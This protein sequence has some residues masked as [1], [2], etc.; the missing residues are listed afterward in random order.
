MSF[1]IQYADV[2]GLNLYAM[3]YGADH[4]GSALQYQI[5]QDMA[6]F[7]SADFTTG[8][9]IPLSED[10]V[11]KGLYF[12][13]ALDSLAPLPFSQYNDFNLVIYERIGAAPYVAS[14]V[15][16]ATSQVIWDGGRNLQ[17]Y[18]TPH[19][20]DGTFLGTYQYDQT[21]RFYT[22]S[23]NAFNNALADYTQSFMVQNPSGINV[24]SGTLS[25][26]DDVSSLGTLRASG[27]N[28]GYGN[29]RIMVSGKAENTILA[30]EFTFTLAPAHVTGFNTP[31]TAVESLG[32]A[33]GYVDTGSATTTTFAT[34]LASTTNDFY[35]GQIL[36]FTSG[37]LRGVGRIISDYV[38]A[39]RTIVT[40]KAFTAAPASGSPFVILPLGGELGVA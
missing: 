36:Y 37:S 18:S 40:N 24:A 16:K 1:I 22:L 12:S 30:T 8:F 10:G 28:F 23:F 20:A 6:M 38:G 4:D 14:D 25:G 32:W 3:L 33:S 21:V 11:I 13:D 9:Y 39:T 7:N 27:S 26:F 15:I 34:N 17:D 35:N 5:S 19:L 2:T 29:Y 31:P